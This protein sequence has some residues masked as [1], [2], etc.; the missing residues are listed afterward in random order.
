MLQILL[1]KTDEDHVLDGYDLENELAK[2]GIEGER[3]SIYRDIKEI[4]KVYFM[5]ENKCTIQE[6]DKVFDEKKYGESDLLIAYSTSKKNQGFYARPRRYTLDEIRLLAECVYSAKFL[7]ASDSKSLANIVC[8]YVSEHQA[9][10]IRHDALLVDRVKTNNRNVISNIIT[11]NQAMSRKLDGQPHTPEKINFKYLKASI[12]N[13]SKSVERRKGEWYIVS[14]YKLLINDGNYY[15]LAFDDEKQAMRT[16]RVDR[17]KDVALMDEPRDGKEAFDAINLQD[18]AKRAFNMYGG[19][20]AR[21]TLR[22]INPL[23]DA[24]IDRFGTSGAWYIAEDD[25]HF[26]VS[27]DVEISDQFFGWL[28]GFGKRVKL[29][30]PQSVVDDFSAYLDKIREMY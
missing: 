15:L 4:N 1:Q 27:A 17:M 8:D 3:R 19:M 21:V 12:N 16:Y 20:P 6:A 14:P 26:T 10:S 5:L 28:L 22:F 7:S 30:S 25:R 23:L 9:E 18:Y 2:F 24:A 29:L 11:I 13:V